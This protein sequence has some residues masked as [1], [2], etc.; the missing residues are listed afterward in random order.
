VHPV[1]GLVVYFCKDFLGGAI[2]VDYIQEDSIVFHSQDT[3]VVRGFGNLLSADGVVGW[4]I[5]EDN[6]VL[7]VDLRLVEPEGGFVINAEFLVVEIPKVPGNTAPVGVPSIVRSKG[8]PLLIIQSEFFAAIVADGSVMFTVNRPHLELTCGVVVDRVD[9]TNAIVLPSFSRLALRQ[10]LRFLQF[11]RAQP[12]LPTASATCLELWPLQIRCFK[13]FLRHPV[14][15]TGPFV[16]SGLWCCR[17]QIDCADLPESYG[18]RSKSP[19]HASCPGYR[20]L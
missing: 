12:A 5:P 8:V 7:P 16:P 13:S 19:R 20:P 10:E 6:P 3:M 18:G 4:A 15:A 9:P 17:M 2:V 11:L 1:L 14:R